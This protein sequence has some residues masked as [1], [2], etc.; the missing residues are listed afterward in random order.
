MKS[1]N[2]EIKIK[3]WYFIKLTSIYNMVMSYIIVRLNLDYKPV[4]DGLHDAAPI[5]YEGVV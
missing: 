4:L 2:E 1:I 5:D 3:N